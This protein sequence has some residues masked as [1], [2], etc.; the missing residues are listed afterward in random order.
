M[1]SAR[2]T[3]A[4]A[5]ESRDY[6]VDSSLTPVWGGR[7]Q[8]LYRGEDVGLDPDETVYAVDS[9][10]VDLCVSLLLWGR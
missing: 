1:A 8:Q 6:R 10:T 5:N 4:P 7:G 3:L 9:I 2:R